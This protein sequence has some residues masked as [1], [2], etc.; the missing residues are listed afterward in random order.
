MRI[1]AFSRTKIFVCLLAFSISFIACVVI[2]DACMP[3][4]E[5]PAVS[6]KLRYLKR[7]G[8]AYNVLFIGSSRVHHQIIPEL[9]DRLMH[10]AGIEVRSFN[11]G[12]DGIRP[13]EDAFL[14]EHALQNRH[15]PVLWVIQEANPIRFR[16]GEQIHDGLRGSYWRDGPRMLLLFR[17]LLTGQAPGSKNV[18][19]RFGEFLHDSGDFW[20]HC[21]L[22]LPKGLHLGQGVSILRGFCTHTLAVTSTDALGERLDGFLSAGNQPMTAERTGEY[23]KD[24][25]ALEHSPAAIDYGDPTSQQLIQWSQ[26]L[27][28]RHGGRLILVDPP[29]TNDSKFYPDSHYGRVPPVFDFS[30]AHQFPELY[31]YDKRKDSGHLNQAGAELFTRL[32]VKRLL[33]LTRNP[34]ARAFRIPPST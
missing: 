26:Q 2:N 16:E 25:A 27:V 4:P 34:K 10:E 7:S 12:I 6:E 31:A 9:F 21:A 29:T 33:L 30:D 20:G 32:I 18:W 14:L 28:E 17:R 11:L 22:W 3:E 8:D 19:Q 24:M 5:V 1:P 23:V 13:P 15:K